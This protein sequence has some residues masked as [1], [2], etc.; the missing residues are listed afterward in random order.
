MT[1]TT[2]PTTT[3]PTGTTPPT[4]TTSPTGTGPH[5][6]GPSGPGSPVAS[7]SVR[8]GGDGELELAV[9]VGGRVMVVADLHLGAD[10]SVGDV[11]AA[12]EIVGAVEAWSGPGVVVLAGNTVVPAGPTGKRGAGAPAPGAEGA[13]AAVLAAHPRFVTALRSFADGG[14]RTVVVLPGDRD[15]CLAWSAPDRA[16]VERHLGARLALAVDLAV[17]TGA[18]C[19]RVRIEPGHALD[20][21]AHRDDPCNRGE[22]P[23][24]HH[25]RHELFPAV[26][27]Q[28]DTG[29][30]RRDDWLAGME[31][32]DDPAAFP[33]FLASRLAYR[34]LGR[35][36]W[37]LLV[38]V[39]L[40]VVFRLPALVFRHATGLA[41]GAPATVLLLVAAT[42]LE[43]V[44]LA[45]VAVA[46]VR[47]TWRAL[48]SLSLGE[49]GREPN[50]EARDRARALIADGYAGLVTGY[51]CRAEL[52]DLGVGFY[53]NAG[54]SGEVVSEVPARLSGLGLPPVFN[55]TR[56]VSWVELEAGS[57]LRVRLLHARQAVSGATLAERLVAGRDDVVT[58]DL[59]PQLVASHPGGASWPV[60][61]SGQL[62]KRRIRRLAALFVGVAGFISLISSLSEPLRDRLRDVRYVFPIV[63]PE[64]AAAITAFLGVALL[65]LARGVRRGQ[66]RAWYATEVILLAAGVLH[67]LKGV[68]VEEAVVAL[69]VAAFLWVNRSSFEGATDTPPLRGGLLVWLG[70]ATA[71]VLA[72]TIGIKAGTMIDHV[73]DRGLFGRHHA[74]SAH[75]FTISWVRAFQAT[76]ERMVGVSH[77]YLPHLVDRFFAPAMT[78]ATVGL[79][80]ALAIL[81]FRPVVA[82]RRLEATGASDLARARAVFGRHGS[83]TLDYFALRPDKQF[84]FWGDT[85]VAYAVYGGVCLVSPDPIGPVTEREPAWRAFRAFVDGNGWALGGL[86]AGEEWLPIYGATGMH[87]LYVGDEGVVRTERF[88]LD[89]GRFKGLR[90]AVN[91]VAKKGYT[92]SFHDPAALDP[93]LR[94]ALEE[95]MTKSR[96]GD[97]E[98]GFSMTLGRVFEPEDRGLLLAVVHG[99]APEGAPSGSVGA[100]VAF[101]QYV[102]APGI[103][104]Y[105]LD[106]MRRD[107]GEHP[108]GLI[109]FA[110]VETIRHLKASG[111]AGLGLNFATM[112]A[113]V[114]GEA[115]EGPMQRVQSWLLKRMGDSMQIESLWRFNAKYDPDWLP[116]YATYDAPENA[117]AVAVAIARAESFWELPVVGRFLVP[118]AGAECAEV[119][120]APGGAAT[121]AGDGVA[122]GCGA[123]SAT[124]GT[125]VPATSAAS[126]A[127]GPGDARGRHDP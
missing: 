38:P 65:V 23:M 64:A 68:D 87:N 44:L 80:L 14:G 19:R 49:G 109:D 52:A 55:A 69:A 57:T 83:G 101:C 118:S 125:P 33:R 27:H 39:L 45:A 71:T 15:S 120:A 53:A 56:Q 75:R 51:T 116:R 77:V 96:R 29:P 25:L 84:W 123:P 1:A 4:G 78:T 16:A 122:S 10:P 54:C 76:V 62:H 26:R 43:L 41:H 98:R 81:V 106:L 37:L 47:R 79:V 7:A 31:R 126:G 102:P 9:P 21:L 61:R 11:A 94:T 108:N 127:A 70:T 2:P 32:L 90:Q 67:L 18:G 105:S 24:S 91:R 107:D 34:K 99:P 8:P 113:V 73:T 36:A 92:I 124:P 42:V 112:R 35:R 28:E 103:G 40:A 104:G 50:R 82:R 111:C 88:T 74:A 58:K 85:V 3:S 121:G 46:S 22:S 59:R 93:D 100:P 97:V 63:V 20:P 5:A 6:T 30:A 110:V 114:A 72:G 66:R 13:A 12:A 117:L 48:A 17:D 95:V 119:A 115:G 86:G 60:Q 89:G